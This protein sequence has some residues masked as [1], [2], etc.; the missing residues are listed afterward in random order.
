MTPAQLLAW[1]G[2]KRAELEEERDR[3]TGGRPDRVPLDLR[4]Q[5]DLLEDLEQLLDL[6]DLPASKLDRGWD[7]QPADL[8]PE[9]PEGPPAGVATHVLPVALFRCWTGCKLVPVAAGRWR[10]RTWAYN[11]RRSWRLEEARP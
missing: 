8:V 11:G 5:L 2:R 4:A 1:V 9:T 10:L 6:A 7:P 3:Y